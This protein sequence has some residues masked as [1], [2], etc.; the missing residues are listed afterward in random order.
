MENK[1]SKNIPISSEYSFQAENSEAKRLSEA[2]SP[3]IRFRAFG[4]TTEPRTTCKLGS[5]KLE[6]E[7]ALSY[8]FPAWPLPM[9]LHLLLNIQINAMLLELQIK[10]M[11]LLKN[12]WMCSS[13]K[14]YSFLSFLSYGESYSK[15]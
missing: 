5:S 12:W 1:P 2:N 14:E 9:G 10:E 3:I 7:A 4:T 13:F 6:N 15:V 8:Q 11:G